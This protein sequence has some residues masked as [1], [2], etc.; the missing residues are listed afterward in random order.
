MMRECTGI[1]I[2]SAV[3]LEHEGLKGPEIAR[4]LGMPKGLESLR[5]RS[6]YKVQL[7]EVGIE[8]I[9]RMDEALYESRVGLMSGRSKRGGYGQAQR[10]G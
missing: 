4:I 7:L 9:R 10:V 2:E 3:A 1:R 8:L 5:A 6:E